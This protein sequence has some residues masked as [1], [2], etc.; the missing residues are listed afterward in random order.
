MPLAESHDLSDL[1]IT[2][3]GMDAPVMSGADHHH[4]YENMSLY[5][6]QISSNRKIIRSVTSIY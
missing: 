3:A 6:R 4:I 1:I 5:M 2:S